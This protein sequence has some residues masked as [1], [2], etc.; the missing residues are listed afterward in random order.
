[1]AVHTQVDAVA[2]Q[3]D[4]TNPL[5][6]PQ[7]VAIELPSL[8]R[9][10]VARA[11]DNIPMPNVQAPLRSCPGLHKATSV[12]HPPL[13][14]PAMAARPKLHVVPVVEVQTPI[15]A[16]R[17]QQLAFE[18]PHLSLDAVETFVPEDVVAFLSSRHTPP[19]GRHPR[20]QQVLS[21]LLT[22]RLLPSLTLQITVLQLL[23]K[24][25]R[26]TPPK[27]CLIWL[28]MTMSVHVDILGAAMNVSA[29]IV[30]PRSE[31]P[32]PR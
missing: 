27:E 5:P 30:M 24:P 28:P 14:R 20:H 1:M 16:P 2:V 13:V 11:R 4:A 12:P 15:A 17:L 9:L 22:R 21:L 8:A 19:R 32:F 31:Q 18:I 3:V 7:L 23:R 6:R 26:G 25:L 10:A 29:R